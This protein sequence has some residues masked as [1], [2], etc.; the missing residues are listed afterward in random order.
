MSE[1]IKDATFDYLKWFQ[2]QI[3]RSSLEATAW[4]WYPVKNYP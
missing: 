4:E 2:K 3:G 1:E